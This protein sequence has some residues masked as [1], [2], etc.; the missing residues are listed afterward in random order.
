LREFRWLTGAV[1]AICLLAVFV[2]VVAAAVAELVRSPKVVDVILAGLNVTYWAA[3]ILFFTL[4]VWAIVEV[5]RAIW[6]KGK[7]R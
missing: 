2:M 4:C 3:P 6:A 1:V 7:S 5:A